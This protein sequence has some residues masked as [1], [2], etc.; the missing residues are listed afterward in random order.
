L[1]FV[2]ILHFEEVVHLHLVLEEVSIVF[3]GMPFFCLLKFVQLF[4]LTRSVLEL[5]VLFHHLFLVNIL[6]RN[7]NTV[8][9]VLE[10]L[11]LFL[12]G[13]LKSLLISLL[14]IIFSQR[15]T[16]GSLSYISFQSKFDVRNWSILR[17]LIMRR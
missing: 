1:F 8:E 4:H 5:K 12:A 2:R 11:V 15:S 17:Y 7:K 9:V 14:F 10:N 3:F 6:L 13:N 16:S